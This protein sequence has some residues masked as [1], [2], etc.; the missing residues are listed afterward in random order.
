[1]PYRIA[2]LGMFVAASA[3]FGSDLESFGESGDWAILVDPSAGHG[4][5]MQKTFE[6]QTLVQMGV[7]PLRQ[8]AFFA[9][10]NPEWDDIEEGTEGVVRIDFGDTLFEGSVVGTWLDGVPGGFAFFDNPAFI[11][12]FAK[13]N[14][15]TVIGKKSG[16]RVEIDLKG[17][18]RALSAVRSCQDQQPKD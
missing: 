14:S 7:L 1:M 13:R 5:L 8:G 18:T 2:V 6:D 10:Y 15:V 3:A 12:E 9:V 16:H 11:D 4:C 17:T